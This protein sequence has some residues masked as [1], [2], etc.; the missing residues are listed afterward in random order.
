MKLDESS[1]LYTLINEP[2]SFIFVLI[3]VL[4]FSTTALYPSV[5]WN[6]VFGKIVWFRL[7]IPSPVDV[8][9]LCSVRICWARRLSLQNNRPQIWHD[10]GTA[11]SWWASSRLERLNICPHLEQGRLW[12]PGLISTSPASNS[13]RRRYLDKWE[14]TTIIFS[15]TTT[16]FCNILTSKFLSFLCWFM[17]SVVYSLVDL[18]YFTYIVL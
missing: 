3:R 1:S 5:S 9:V 7:M 18:S 12:G 2:L 10:V 14:N 16:L 4:F 13:S 8:L 15:H 17:Y 6:P 11:E